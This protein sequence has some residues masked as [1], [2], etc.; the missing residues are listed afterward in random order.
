MFRKQ[1]SMS[2]RF[3]FNSE[4]K[5]DSKVFQKSKEDKKGQEPQLK[6]DFFPEFLFPTASNYI[7]TL[8]GFLSYS[9]DHF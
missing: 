1:N 2:A 4:K 6:N 3:H 9:C 8:M 7:A 5:A